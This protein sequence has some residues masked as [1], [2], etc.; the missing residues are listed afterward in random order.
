MVMTFGNQHHR[1]PATNSSSY[2]ERK[3]VQPKEHQLLDV[4][5]CPNC[6][7]KRRP[8]RHRW[9]LYASYFDG[10]CRSDRQLEMDTGAWPY[11]WARKRGTVEDVD[12]SRSLCHCSHL[13]LHLNG[14]WCHSHKWRRM[15]WNCVFSWCHSSANNKQLY[16]L[17]L[18]RW[19]GIYF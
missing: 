8:Y 10:Q 12:G 15:W 3:I 13:Y 7:P 5:M 9:H 11:C 17:I 16:D 19:H 6:G 18:V 14:T 1:T 2:F 4:E